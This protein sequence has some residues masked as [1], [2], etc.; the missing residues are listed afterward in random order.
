ME[1]DVFNHDS[2]Y[3]MFTSTAE[4]LGVKNGLVM[5]PVRIALSGML[6]TPGGAVEI[7]DILGKDEALRRIDLAIAQLVD[8]DA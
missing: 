1:M 6:V 3:I 4:K 5:W 7:A 8:I 2:I